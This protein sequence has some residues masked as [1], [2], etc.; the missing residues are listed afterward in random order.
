MKCDI[1]YENVLDFNGN[2][3]D[4]IVSG[5]DVQLPDD[6]NMILNKLHEKDFE[7]NVVGGA[8]RDMILG[9]KP[10]DYDF[11]TSAKP[12]EIIEIFEEYNLVLDG[13]KHGTV[14]VIVNNERYEITSYRIDGEYNDNRKPDSVEF[15]DD[16]YEDLTRRDFTINAIAY[17]PWSGFAD[18][19]HGIRDIN[20]GLIR[21]VGNPYS[22]FKEDGLRVLRAIRFAA[23]LGFGVDD[24][25]SQ[26]IKDSVH[27]L[28]NISKE[29]IQSELIKILSCR[30]CGNNA[31]FDYGYL[32]SQIIPELKDTIEKEDGKLLKYNAWLHTLDCLDYFILNIG[33]EE[34]D[35]I[36]SRLAMFLH[37]MVGYSSDTAKDILKSL[38][39]SNDIVNKTSELI[40]YMNIDF[41]ESRI[42]AKHLLK[43]LG[44]EQTKRL[45]FTAYGSRVMSVN[46]TKSN[47][48]VYK[49]MNSYSIETLKIYVDSIIENNECYSLK[50][51]AINGDDLKQ[52]GISEGEKI[53]NILNVLLN[54][55]IE[56]NL[57][58]DKNILIQ[59]AFN[60][61]HMI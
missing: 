60:V 55:V 2:V 34:N 12:D 39:F 23:Q 42:M 5:Y 29:R 47:P 46:A 10:H 17:N 40:G 15:C 20:I 48:D 8:C 53:G 24:D 59:A 18:P 21:C 30:H 45:L 25:T 54:N 49:N 6:V 22:R 51:L 9:I 33:E 36:I 56:G 28:D 37:N 4:T 3:V 61:A 58:N 44:I 27:L 52:I 41:K 31:L 38:K 1:D 19:Y 14:A 11:C 7:V 26:A 13:L 32:V 35:D 16:I 57:Q 50:Q 43:D